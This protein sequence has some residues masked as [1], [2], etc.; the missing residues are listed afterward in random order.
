[1]LLKTKMRITVVH[2]QSH[3]GST[4]HIAQMLSEKLA[5]DVTEFYLPKDFGS[6]CKIRNVMASPRICA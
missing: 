3:K 4:Y 6:F 5:G 2:G 1:M